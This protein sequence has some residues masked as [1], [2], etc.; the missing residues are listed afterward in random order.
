MLED[1]TPPVRVFPCM[2]RTVLGNLSTDDQKILRTALGDRDA[3]SHRALGKAL[4]ERGIPLGE[5]IIRDRRDR[6]C[7]DCVCRVESC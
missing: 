2:I 6:P 3:W 5:K 1:L 4:T 7:D